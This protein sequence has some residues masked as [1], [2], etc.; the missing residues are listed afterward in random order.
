MNAEK[1]LKVGFQVQM[2]TMCS[3]EKNL[4][5]VFIVILSQLENQLWLRIYLAKQIKSSK[6]TNIRKKNKKTTF[7]VKKI[8]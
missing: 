5:I 6:N 8:Y 3:R 7:R 1:H 2:S 4:L